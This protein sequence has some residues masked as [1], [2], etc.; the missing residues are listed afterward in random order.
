MKKTPII[1]VLA[2]ISVIIL[3]S[4]IEKV[5]LDKIGV[6]VN[7]SGGTVQEDLEPGYYFVAPGQRLYHYDPTVQTFSMGGADGAQASLELTGKDQYKTRFDVTTVF[8]IQDGKAHRFADAIGPLKAKMN[9]VVETKAE[10]A[11]WDALGRLDTQDFYNV[12]KREKARALAKEQ[13]GRDLAEVHIELIDILFR[14]INYDA[15]LETILVQKQLFDQR[16]ALNIEKAK[17]EAELEK[18]Q[19]IERETEARVKVIEE[20]QTQEIANIEA[21]TDARINEIEADAEL[22]AQGNIAQA[23]KYRRTKIS[24]GELARTQAKAKGEKAIN[25]AYLGNGGQAYIAKQMV[26]AISFGEI[27]V[28]TNQMNPFDVSQ[29]L[30]MLGLDEKS[31]TEGE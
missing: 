20:E 16:K 5:P 14:D 26:D 4:R 24:E 30:A 21:N 9:D 23:E 10:R 13:L 18:T 2:V 19:S 17:L 3:L 27:E 22:Q 1:I 31:A 7:L 28:N 15:N 25:E 8:R 29:L 11:L 6:K 12:E